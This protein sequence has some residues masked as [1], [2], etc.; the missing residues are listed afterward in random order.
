MF[1]LSFKVVLS[2]KIKGS[3]LCPPH[4]HI[5]DT[6]GLVG[7]FFLKILFI[8][9]PFLSRCLVVPDDRFTIKLFWILTTFQDEWLFS[10]VTGKEFESSVKSLLLSTFK[11]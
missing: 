2:K 3:S 9:N 10:V 4:H 6:F 5:F 8:F 7:E 11:G 1:E